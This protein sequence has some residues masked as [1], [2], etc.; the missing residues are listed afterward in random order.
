MAQIE[1]AYRYFI[2]GGKLLIFGAALAFVY[3]KVFDDKDTDNLIRVWST[4]WTDSNRQVMLILA[5]LLLPF[6]WGIEAL[7]WRHL[8]SKVEPVPLGKAIRAT[9]S[10]ATI[11]L[12]TPNRVG[13]FLG[14]VMYLE[15][16]NRVRGSLASVYGNYCQLMVT[17]LFG[18]AGLAYV[19]ASEVQLQELSQELLMSFLI[20][21]VILSVLLIYFYFVPKSILRIIMHFRFMQRFRKQLMILDSY[22]RRDLYVV[23]GWSVLRYLVFSIQFFLVLQSFGAD[24]GWIIGLALI[25]MVYLLVAAIPSLLLGNLGIRESAVLLVLGGFAVSNELLIFASLSIW[26]INL[27]VPGLIG[28]V[29]ILLAK[30]KVKGA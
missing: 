15:P 3:Y 13:G 7:K 29:F 8:I 18:A 19:V 10:G 6:N 16:E 14:R 27:V 1:K 9:L 30:V 17:V 21:A 11:S 28:G 5:C 4:V 25:A 24:W 12:L 23:L 2:L 20:F 26:I 22:D